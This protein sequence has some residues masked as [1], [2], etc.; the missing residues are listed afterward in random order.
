[1]STDDVRDRRSKARHLLERVGDNRANYRVLTI[2]CAKDHRLVEIFG[3]GDQLVWV[4]VP[5]GT[6][7]AFGAG[8]LK[9]SG[10]RERV[11]ILDAAATSH[12]TA[13]VGGCKCE[14][15]NVW[16]AADWVLAQVARDDLPKSLRVVAPRWQKT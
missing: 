5:N 13:P 8:P 10:R 16:P 12:A 11:G 1:M 7:W 2:I 14:E 9:S 4:G 15:A 6:R 3:I